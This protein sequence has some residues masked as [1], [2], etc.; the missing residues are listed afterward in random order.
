MYQKSQSYDVRLLRYGVRQAEFFVTLGHFLPFQLTGN[1][2]NQNLKKN[3]RKFSNFTH[4]HHKWQSHD[5]WF[6]KY[7][8]QQTEFFCHAGPFFALLPPYGSRK[9][10]FWK[11]EQ[12]IWRYYHFTNVHHK[13]KSVILCMVPVIWS[14]TDK[15]FC[16]FGSFFALLP[17]PPPPP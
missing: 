16:H 4:L 1:P 11:N 14:A 15:F 7:G 3:T 12:H 10:K 5:T 2:E 8:A 13:L 9:S 6:L 17:L